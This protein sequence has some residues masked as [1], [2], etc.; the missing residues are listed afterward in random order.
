MTH[1][2][3]KKGPCSLKLFRCNYLF[4][5]LDTDHFSQ[6][7]LYTP[8]LFHDW[9]TSRCIHVALKPAGV[10]IAW[11][12]WNRSVLLQATGLSVIS[13]FHLKNASLHLRNTRV[14]PLCR[15]C[16]W[17]SHPITAPN[18]IFPLM[19]HLKSS[20]NNT[21]TKEAFWFQTP[22]F[23][24]KFKNLTFKNGSRLFLLFIM[25]PHQTL[26]V[27]APFNNLCSVAQYPPGSMFLLP[28]WNIH[29]L[30]HKPSL[31]QDKDNI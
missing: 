18:K 9:C 6:T 21:Q 10:F 11:R 28:F 26:K 29:Y 12:Q 8:Q 5:S 2:N 30:Q 31:G 15:Y 3:N 23:W 7:C 27:T 24:V 17:T 4:K 14:L 16:T 25:I 22:A 1:I 13:A 20:L 19:F